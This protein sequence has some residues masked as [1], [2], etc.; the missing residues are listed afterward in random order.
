MAVRMR[1]TRM[2]RKKRPFY[3][4]VVADAREPRD[5]KYIECIGTYNPITDPVEVNILD[6]R[7]AYWLQQG[8]QPSDTVYNLLQRKGIVYKRHLQKKGLDEAQ[9][10][11]EMK[12]WDVLQIERQRKADALKSSA[13][14]KAKPAPVV[15]APAGEAEAAA[16]EETPAEA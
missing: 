4:I 11:E 12:K 16:A 5:G 2:G 3:R 1:L 15:E 10:A 9:I 13:K 8:A 7:A 14:V 6:E